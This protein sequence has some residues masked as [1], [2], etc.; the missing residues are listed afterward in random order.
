MIHWSVYPDICNPLFLSSCCSTYI[1]LFWMCGP[2]WAYLPSIFESEYQRIKT[3]PKSCNHI[4]LESHHHIYLKITLFGRVDCRRGGRAY[5]PSSI[6]WIRKS[7]NARPEVKISQGLTKSKLKSWKKYICPKSHTRSFLKIYIMIG[8]DHIHLKSCEHICFRSCDYICLK[9]SDHIFVRSC[10]LIFLKRYD[11]ICLKS[12]DHI[13]PKSC[14]HICPKSCEYIFSKA[15]II[16]VPKVVNIF[17]SKVVILF[18]SKIVIT[19]VSNAVIK[20]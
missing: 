6:F 14:E 13:C 20:S 9:S 11:F 3:C 12:C 15:V 16:L 7:N 10:D 1:T 8:F 4:C 19:F 2:Q 5:L 17:V 18:V